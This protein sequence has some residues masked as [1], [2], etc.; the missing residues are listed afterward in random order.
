[1]KLKRLVPQLILE[2]IQLKYRKPNFDYEWDEATRY[3]EFEKLGY[4]NWINVAKTGYV[5]DYNSI[6]TVLGNVDLNLGN[7]ESEK[8][9]RVV[10]QLKTGTIEIP[11]VVKFGDTDYDLL[12]GN[13]RLASIVSGGGNPKIWVIDIS[14][15]KNL[16]PKEL[17]ISHEMD[18]K[19]R[20]AAIYDEPNYDGTYY[21][22]GMQGKS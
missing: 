5:T 11:I 7:L 9:Q 18:A 4:D 22:T 2:A 12:A 16:S 1:M 17:D 19:N 21:Y 6:K 3:P 14:N 13:T 10:N 20:E 15:E 8:V